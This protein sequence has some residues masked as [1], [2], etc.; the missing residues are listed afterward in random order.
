MTSGKLLADRSDLTPQDPL[1]AMSLQQMQSFSTSSELGL[2]DYWRILLKRKWTIVTFVVVVVTAALLISWRMTPIYDG[3]A[4]INW[5]RQAQ[6]FFKDD[7]SQGPAEAGNDP[8]SM[9]TQVRIIGSDFLALDVIHNLRLDQ[10]PDFAGSY[11]I[12]TSGGLTLADTARQQLEREDKLIRLFHENLRVQQVGNTSI[13]EIKYSNPNAQLAADIA[14]AVANGYIEQNIKAKF[15]STMQAADLLSKQLA[16]LQIKVETSEARLVEYQK[17]HG[18]IIT[19][20]KTNLTIE[21]LN[22]LSK[23]LADAQADRIQ[24]DSIYEL[25]KTSNADAVSSVLQD[26]VISSLRQQ[27]DDLQAQ[28]AQLTVQF[29]PSYP[30]VIQLQN[31]LKQVN[32][33]YHEQIALAVRRLQNDYAAAVA[34]EQMLQSALNEQTVEANKLNEDTIEL[35]VLQQE[36]DSNRTLYNGLLTKLKEASLE[37]G[38]N[39]TN[40]RIVDP[41]RVPLRPARPNIIRN[42]EFALLLGLVGGV[43]VIFVLEALDMTVRTPDQIENVSG[44]PTVGIIPFRVLQEESAQRSGIGHT[45]KPTPV[46]TAPLP[47]PI[48]FVDPQSVISE[49]YRALRTSLLLSN[50]GQP[51]RSVL[52]TSALPQDGKTTSSVNTAIVMAQQGKRVLLVDCDLRR[53]LLNK[54]FRLRPEMGL[55]NVLSGGA[56]AQDI[57]QATMQPN[58]FLIPSGPLPPH[59]SE[60]LSSNLMQNLLRQWIEEY[61]HVIIDSPPVLSATDGVLLSVQV[62]I[63][64][65]VVRAGKTT[66]PALR[67]ARDLL[68]SVKANLGGVVVNG[69]DMSSPDYYYYYSGYGYKYGGKYGGYYTDKHAPKLNSTGNG[70]GASEAAETENPA[71]TSSGS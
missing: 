55:S 50:P 66:T 35:K 70:H 65:L 63:T 18:I 17:E 14:N 32:E 69:V 23:E 68:L 31:R 34:R 37:A 9:E 11:A 46:A 41:A 33:S 27:L 10:R 16:D 60:L 40:I 48:T 21:K 58:L 7:Q 36:A 8:L 49:A 1:R 52:F 67:R 2:S 13:I 62:D 45:L 29:G 22:Q 28:Y 5:T 71:T 39:S 26:G 56:R 59:P 64:V 38:L 19:D 12:K 15:N 24:K 61:D 3:V 30:T 42:L 57:I 53:P 4:R 6:N 25:A 51:P 47:L 43:A 54:I 44:L 20:D